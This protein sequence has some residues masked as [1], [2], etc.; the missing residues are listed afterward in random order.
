MFNNVFFYVVDVKKML[1]LAVFLRQVHPVVSYITY[2][3]ITSLYYVSL[4]RLM[5]N[6]TRR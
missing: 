3:H 5:S 4:L 2:T 1:E 6:S